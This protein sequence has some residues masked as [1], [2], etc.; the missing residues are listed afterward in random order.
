MSK[1]RRCTRASRAA[2]SMRRGGRNGV[3]DREGAGRGAC[4]RRHPSRSQAVERDHRRRR[5]RQG[6]G[7]RHRENDR[8]RDDDIGRR[9]A[10]RDVR[11]LGFIGTASYA[12]PEQMVS[13]A[14]DERADL[15][16]LGVV[17][18]EMISGRRPFPGNDP[19]SLAS[20][21]LSHD[22]PA[23]SSTGKIVPA[24]PRSAGG[25]A[26]RARPRSAS[27][28]RRTRSVLLF[29]R[30]TAASARAICHRR[31]ACR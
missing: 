9:R 10:I 11:R 6:A 21:K 26:P 12:A 25:L 31:N 16:A 23:L 1:A 28:F 22:A 8:D 27:R 2:P 18:F 13:S 29:G 30:S 15:Y 7:F 14:V 20:S 24:G 3:A 17:L 19:V 4:A 5:P